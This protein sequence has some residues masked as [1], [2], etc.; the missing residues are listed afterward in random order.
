MSTSRVRE[1]GLMGKG[2]IET[3]PEGE[4]QKK[5]SKCLSR[6]MPQVTSAKER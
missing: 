1:E 2:H 6:E 3:P 4:F 5:K